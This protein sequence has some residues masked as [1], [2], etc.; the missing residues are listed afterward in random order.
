MSNAYTYIYNMARMS[1]PVEQAV[2]TTRLYA[3]GRSG[4]SETSRFG[5]ED[6]L[7]VMFNNSSTLPLNVYLLT[8]GA[9][10][11]DALRVDVLPPQA[12]GVYAVQS[13]DHL[14]VNRDSPSSDTVTA[15]ERMPR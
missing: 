15:H 7:V 5:A 4:W 3:C 8:P 10:P 12:Q 2:G 14:L 6:R 1:A 9:V 11:A 13:N